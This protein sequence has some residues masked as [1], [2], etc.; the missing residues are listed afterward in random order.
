L[1]GKQVFSTM[2]LGSVDLA[3]DGEVW[4]LLV[5]WQDEIKVK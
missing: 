2:D 3:S 5:D 1:K 4:Q